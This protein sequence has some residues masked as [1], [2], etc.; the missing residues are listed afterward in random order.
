MITISLMD[1]MLF[2]LALAGLVVLVFFALVLKNLLAI[3]NSAKEIMEDKRKEIDGVID[4]LPV[5]MNNVND[6]SARASMLVDDI[7][8][9]VIKSKDDVTGIV[10]SVNRTMDDVNE[11]SQTATRLAQQVEYTADNAVHSVNSLTDNLVDASR[12][13]S[14]NK[15]NILDYIFIFKDYFDELR[16]IFFGRR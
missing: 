5:L 6:I 1:V 9:V 4:E 11:V 13:F 8:E 10:A 15:E 16:R 14:Y 7:N 3:I 2:I 12:F